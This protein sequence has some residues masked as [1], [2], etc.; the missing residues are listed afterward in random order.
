MTIVPTLELL[1]PADCFA[2][3]TNHCRVV[4]VTLLAPENPEAEVG[5]EAA[6]AATALRIG[7]FTL[8]E[9]DCPSLTGHPNIRY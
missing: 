9:L 4:S 5:V 3:P 8:G 1:T 2:R 6:L 7:D